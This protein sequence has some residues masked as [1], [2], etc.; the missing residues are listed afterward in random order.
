MGI[1]VSY[2]CLRDLELLKELNKQ[3]TGLGATHWAFFEE[4]E[5]LEAEW[6]YDGI[7]FARD[8]GG[9][10]GM[11][12]DGALAKLKMLKKAYGIAESLEMLPTTFIDC[13]SDVRFNSPSVLFDFVCGSNEFRGFSGFV[14]NDLKPE[15]PTH[16]TWY[17]ATGC[18]KSFHSD[19]LKKLF[20]SNTD[21]FI[22]ELITKGITPSEDAFLSYSFQQFGWTFIN[23]KEKY[24]LFTQSK[25]YGNL[26]FDIIS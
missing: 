22:A 4:R 3:L 9:D 25:D 18:V 26:N 17:Y 6:E 13:D 16:G 1:V 24:K 10:N 19:L 14:L 15:P 20:E 8:N 11:G 12:R 21:D 23:L 5:M 7:K 2:T